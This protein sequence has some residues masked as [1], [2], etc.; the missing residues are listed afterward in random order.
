MAF[1]TYILFF[2]VIMA[3]SST[4]FKPDVLGVTA[5]SG[6][7]TLA[8]E[9]FIVKLG[10]YLLAYPPVLILDLVAYCG[11]KFVGILLILACTWAAGWIGF[12]SSFAVLALFM[13]I[14]MVKT[15]RLIVPQPLEDSHRNT[16]NYALI[17]IAVLQAVFT[18][19][20]CWMDTRNQGG[21]TVAYVPL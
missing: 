16:R 5:S 6:L 15:L 11:Y 12:L 14:F 10:F 13:A 9:V 1:I 7:F 21:Q 2:A 18:G 17:A 4:G 8:L 3:T 20:L 19:I